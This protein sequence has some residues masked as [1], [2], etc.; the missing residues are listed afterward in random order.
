[1]LR[2]ES[3]PPV[4]VPG[5]LK[6]TRE[7]GQGGATEGHRSRD[8]SFN[9]AACSM[10]C[11]WRLKDSVGVVE[12]ICKTINAAHRHDDALS[13]VRCLRASSGCSPSHLHA[14]LFARRVLASRA[15][16]QSVQVLRMHAKTVC[17]FT[18]C[19]CSARPKSQPW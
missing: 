16:R 1:V 15:S 17:Y 11:G 8:F 5:E 3:L 4:C 12:K 14:R 13:A 18:G 6:Q 2:V 19:R 10:S 9:E 7:T